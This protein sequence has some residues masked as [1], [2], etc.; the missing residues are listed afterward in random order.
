MPDLLGEMMILCY[1]FNATS[2]PDYLGNLTEVTLKDSNRKTLCVKSFVSWCRNFGTIESTAGRFLFGDRMEEMDLRL[3]Q[4]VIG[5]S[6]S[7]LEDLFWH[8]VRGTQGGHHNCISQFPIGPFRVDA[9]FDCDG[10]AV[11]I[12][13]DGKEYH[14]WQRDD[15][16]DSVLLH[17][18]GAVIRI[19]YRAMKYYPFATLA[20]IGAWYP[21]FQP[22]RD[23]RTM[24]YIELQRLYNKEVAHLDA[25]DQEDWFCQFNSMIEVY[26]G[27]A[28]YSSATSVGGPRAFLKQGRPSLITRRNGKTSPELLAELRSEIKKRRGQV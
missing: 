15:A 12:E 9:I 19:P 26:T 16:R 10:T 14:D 18:V 3:P 6:E 25:I 8:Y 4:H 24:S 28:P 27:L 20:V 22:I 7:V 11:V 5:P 2:A 13:L 23:D 17:Q 21:R 1:S